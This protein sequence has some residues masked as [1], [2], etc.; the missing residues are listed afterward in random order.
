MK[1]SVKL[2]VTASLGLLVSAASWAGPVILGGDDLTDHGSRSAGGA[3]LE[4][5]LYIEKAISS[6]F[7]TQTRPGALTVD[8][9]ALGSVNPGAGVYTSSNAGGAIN[10]VAN[11]LGR[12]LSFYDGATNIGTFF[13]DLASGAVN[14]G[15]IWIAGTGASNNLVATEGAALTANANAI[16]SF[17]GSGGGLMA[18]GSGPVAYGW[19]TAL[20]PGL[21]EVSGCNSSGATLTAAGSA[22]FPGLS[23]SDI[24]ANA[25]P[26]H[27]HFEGN[28]GGL[29]TLALD[30]SNPARSYIIGAAA[31]GG[32]SITDPPSGVPEP[33]TLLLVGVGLAGLASRRKHAL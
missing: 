4:G 29:T 9:V 20:L 23:N 30:G 18:H 21:T 26:C 11:V 3:N 33:A 5:W 19:L 16:N 27:S 15:V 12:S 28:F 32:G 10:S 13:S 6:L 14:P 7:G 8:I 2:A 1:K 25:G 31:G 17:V 22:A 24:D